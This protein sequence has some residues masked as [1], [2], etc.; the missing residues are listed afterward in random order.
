MIFLETASQLDSMAISLD[1]VLV[2]CRLGVH[3]TFLD[4]NFSIIFNPNFKFQFSKVLQHCRLGVL[5]HHN[6]QLNKEGGDWYPVFR[7][8]F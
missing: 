4:Y 6:S 8:L 2:H 5:G 1:Q 3:N 7:C